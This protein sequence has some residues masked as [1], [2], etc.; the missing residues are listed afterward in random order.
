MLNNE[1]TID[2]TNDKGIESK[3]SPINKN[4]DEKSDIQSNHTTNDKGVESK[5]SPTN[6]NL[7]DKL[8]IQSYHTTD[9]K[10]L[11]SKNSPINKNLDEKTDIQSNHTWIT[12]EETYLKKLSEKAL[13]YK[14]MH[15]RAYK[16]YYMLNI[17]FSLP[18][19][20]LSTITGSI[21]FI[22]NV[23][24]NEKDLITYISG[25]VNLIV[26]L[27]EALTNYFTFGKL[28]E[29][30]RLSSLYWDK[31]I[32][33]IKTELIKPRTDRSN[34][35]EF[36]KYCNDE[37][38]KIEDLSP[39]F[40]DDIIR[41]MNDYIESGIEEE[42]NIN[43]KYIGLYDYILFPCNCR[44]IFKWLIYDKK[45]INDKNISIFKDIEKPEILG[46]F[47]KIEITISD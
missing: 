17:W 11:E 19:I 18:I 42:Y 22:S 31:Y 16:K 45:K 36:L 15:N 12:A 46:Y 24:L 28:V 40:S 14:L 7:D 9:D 6:K 32:L 39:N 37:Y 41:W 25:S 43:Y 34:M 27:L 33:K 29:S 3:N 8:D 13:C 4:L 35:I 44:N 26:A 1:K 20:I 21:S 5:N 30:H 47:S 38:E 10:S 2:D 23:S